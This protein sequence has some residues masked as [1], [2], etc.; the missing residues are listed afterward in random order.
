MWM[1]FLDTDTGAD[2]IALLNRMWGAASDDFK[3]QQWVAFDGL[4]AKK[5]TRGGGFSR[6]CEKG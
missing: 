6:L 1:R 2:V 5:K 4:C 3:V